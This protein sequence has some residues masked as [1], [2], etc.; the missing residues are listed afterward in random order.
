MMSCIFF[1]FLL[2]KGRVANSAV[3]HVNIATE[4]FR[5]RTV[6]PTQTL[7]PIIYFLQ[8]TGGFLPR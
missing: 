1:I 2:L 6:P 3:V 5:Y 4:L 7:P 8:H